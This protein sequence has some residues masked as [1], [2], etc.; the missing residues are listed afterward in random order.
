MASQQSGSPT[1]GVH[2]AASAKEMAPGRSSLCSRRGWL[3]WGAPAEKGKESGCF[4][5]IPHSFSSQLF[6]AH[7][8]PGTTLGNGR[9]MSKAGPPPRV[10]QENPSPLQYLGGCGKGAVGLSSHGGARPTQ[11]A[12]LSAGWSRRLWRWSGCSHPWLHTAQ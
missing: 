1:G 12:A 4:S 11:P 10:G 9:G 8:M 3:T 2:M 5:Q 6:N 7:L